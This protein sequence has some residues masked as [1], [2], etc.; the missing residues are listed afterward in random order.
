LLNRTRRELSSGHRLTLSSLQAHDDD[1]V[2]GIMETHLQQRDRAGVST[3]TSRS[4]GVRS[5]SAVLTAASSFTAASNGHPAARRH[6]LQG[7]STRRHQQKEATTRPLRSHTF[8]AN[9]GATLHKAASVPSAALSTSNPFTLGLARSVSQ[10]QLPSNTPGRI[11]ID[12]ANTSAGGGPVEQSSS[13]NL[14]WHGLALAVTAQQ[15]V[16]HNLQAYRRADVVANASRAR[17]RHARAGSGA[18][19]L[20]RNSSSVSHRSLTGRHR[21]RQAADQEQTR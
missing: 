9:G 8:T 2:N 7:G 13:S 19:P 17:T 12:R 15:R 1:S 6:Q 16:A 5:A 14:S 11:S 10:A 3:P 20:E 4:L 21:K 18:E